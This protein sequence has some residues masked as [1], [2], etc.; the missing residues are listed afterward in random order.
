MTTAS[1]PTNGRGGHGQGPPAPL[2][3]LVVE[4]CA[5][6]RE[7][8][9]ILLRLY[10]FQVDAAADDA[11]ALA[12]ARAAPPDVLLVDVGLAGPD[13][14]AVARRLRELCGRG[15]LVVALTGYGRPCDFRRSAEE[16]FDL[17]LVKPVDPAEVVHL[18]RQHAASLE[19]A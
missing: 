4:D 3:V 18:L 8:L 16:G 9:A 10:G 11:E 6:S 5:E 17:H 12:C 7:S 19:R 1:P 13:G 14:Y 2:R 15:L